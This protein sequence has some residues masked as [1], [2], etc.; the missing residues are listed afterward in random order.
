MQVPH[1]RLTFDDTEI[2]LVRDVVASGQWACGPVVQKAE[3]QLSE[4]FGSKDSV[5]WGF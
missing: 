3:K 2:N 4:I 1:N 5:V